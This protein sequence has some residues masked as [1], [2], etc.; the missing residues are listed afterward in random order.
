MCYLH[1]LHSVFSDH[2][3]ST[4]SAESCDAFSSFLFFFFFH[5]FQGGRRQNL[6]FMRQMSLSR[7]VLVMFMHCSWDP[8][9]LY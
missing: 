9:L 6:L 1:D 7:T 2:L 8:Q 3:D 4:F 5:A